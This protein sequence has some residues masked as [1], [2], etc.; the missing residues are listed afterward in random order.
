MIGKIQYGHFDIN[1]LKGK[2]QSNE[3]NFLNSKEQMIVKGINFIGVVNISVIEKVKVLPVSLG[4]IYKLTN[5]NFK[6]GR[7]NFAYIP[8]RTAVNNAKNILG[9]QYQ[10]GV[11]LFIA[12]IG[13]NDYLT[14]NKNSQQSIPIFFEKQQL[15]NMVEKFRTQRPE[16]I[17]N[18]NI[19]I[20]IITLE[21]L[22]QI[23][24]THNS[25]RLEKVVLVPSTESL[26]FLQSRSSTRQNRATTSERVPSSKPTLESIFPNANRTI[27]DWF[28][29]ES[30]RIIERATRSS[31]SQN[32]NSSNCNQT[33][34]ASREACLSMKAL[35]MQNTTN[36]IIN[37]GNYHFNNTHMDSPYRSNR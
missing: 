23:L 18:N 15:E 27:G 7:L 12:K 22:I 4:N 31:N 5:N 28:E 3:E 16:I 1:N 24:Q 25:Q 14:I 37:T 9:K 35:E 32:S 8:N 36:T 17:A 6:S 26:Q 20:E 11:P 33:N 29:G 21:N 13:D 34:P 19:K 30:R 2:I 10:G